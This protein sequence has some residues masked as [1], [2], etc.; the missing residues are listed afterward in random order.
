MATNSSSLHVVVIP[1]NPGDFYHIY[2]KYSVTKVTT[3]YPDEHNYD[4]H[5]T[6]PDLYAA[7]TDPSNELMYTA[8][9][10]NN[11]TKGKQIYS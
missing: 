1:D 7:D 4:Y 6:V 11:D 10:S 5:F 8:F 2:I 3:E 9:I